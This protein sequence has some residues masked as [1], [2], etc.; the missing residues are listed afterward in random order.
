M[1]D[2]NYNRD[3]MCVVMASDALVGTLM[4]NMLRLAEL[5]GEFY[6]SAIFLAIG[7]N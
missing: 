1:D 2:T 7:M 6:F 4:N 5:D 3:T